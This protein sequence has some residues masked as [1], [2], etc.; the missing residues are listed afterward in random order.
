MQTFL[1]SLFPRDDTKT[2]NDRGSVPAGIPAFRPMFDA[3]G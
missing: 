1:A 3:V 2:Y